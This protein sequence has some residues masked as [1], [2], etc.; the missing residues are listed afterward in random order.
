MKNSLYLIISIFLFVA[1]EQD[2]IATLSNST[3]VV[4]GYLFVGQSV[5]SIR[6]TKSFSYSDTDTTLVGLD[7]LVVNLEDGEKTYPL[8]SIG[9]GYYQNKEVLINPNLTYRLQF[10]YAGTL[11]SAE[12]F[13]PRQK[14]ATLSSSQ[15]R[16]PRIDL[17]QGRPPIDELQ[18][19]LNVEPIELS[20]DNAEGDYYY[21]VIDNIESNPT[22]VFVL[23]DG[24]FEGRRFSFISEPQVIDFYTIQPQREIQQFG[25]HRAIVFRVNLEYVALYDLNGSSSISITQ[26]P[27]NVENGLGIFTGVSSDTLYFEVQRS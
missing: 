22:D 12:T 27:T 18:E 8:T 6:I 15:I 4:D 1:C 3:A 21:V 17:S 5:D 7:Q 16:L 24:G 9:G 14:E 2:S 25:R 20:W 10:E 19:L 11:V 13:T 26:P 23:P